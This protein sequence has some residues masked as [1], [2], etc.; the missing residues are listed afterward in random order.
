MDERISSADAATMKRHAV[1]YLR[2]MAEEIEADQVPVQAILRQVVNN[3]DSST[4][5]KLSVVVQVDPDLE[6]HSHCQFLELP[7]KKPGAGR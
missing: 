5:S 7:P 3:M 4:S 2:A 1:K 6:P